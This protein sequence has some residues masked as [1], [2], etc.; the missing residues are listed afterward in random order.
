MEY[1]LLY[2]YS[3]I[4]LLKGLK[5]F[6]K[7]VRVGDMNFEGSPVSDQVHLHLI[8]IEMMMIV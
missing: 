2:I 4:V 7:V 6:S 8:A 3:I 1:A 5:L